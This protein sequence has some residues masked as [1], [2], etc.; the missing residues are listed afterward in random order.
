MKRVF[1]LV[2]A[3]ML[4]VM[5]AGTAMAARIK[6]TENMNIRRG[7][8]EEYRI[9]AKARRGTE[10]NIRKA[11]TDN[12]ALWYKI[13]SGKYRGYY[14]SAAFS[15]AVPP[16]FKIR[17]RTTGTVNLRDAG[18]TGGDIIRTIGP[19]KKLICTGYRNG[20]FRVRYKGETG[21]VYGYRLKPA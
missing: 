6:L 18:T 1:A 4:V 9:V 19:G 12:E 10:M 21:Y 15:V 11:R 2:I 5:T 20:W 14:V 3:V 7:P 16:R 13:T 8:G 17:V